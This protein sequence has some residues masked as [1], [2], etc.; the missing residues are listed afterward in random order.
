[1]RED[2]AKGHYVHGHHTSV[3]ASHAPRGLAD[4]AP[5]LRPLLAPGQ[6]VLDVGCGPGSITLDM[7]EAVGPEGS[8][9]G[10][11]FSPAAIETARRAAA[12]RGIT[13]VRFE[14]ADLF[15]LRPGLPPLRGRYDVVH[16]HQVLHHLA[17]P[18]AAITVMAALV[19]PGGLLSLREVDYSSTAWTPPS[20]ALSTWLAT[21]RAFMVAEGEHP[22]AGLILPLLAIEAG[23]EPE[24]LTVTSSEWF[25]AD[26]AARRQLAAGWAERVR[27]SSYAESARRH[28]LLD[29]AGLES[30]ASGW[31]EWAQ[32]PRGAFLFRNTEVLARL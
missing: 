32:A 22:D 23:L 7:A 15:A 12:E 16:A 31:I 9:L 18:R 13:N 10:L 28:A 24:A 17:D 2:D 8:V 26:A 21:L 29:D 30:L 14:V 19:A 6:R 1:M 3:L 5:H 4:S 25:Y 27:A 11:D 20:E